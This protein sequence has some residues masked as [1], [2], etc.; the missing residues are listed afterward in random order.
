MMAHNDYRD[1]YVKLRCIFMQHKPETT[2]YYIQELLWK[3][4]ESQ[5]DIYDNDS[6]LDWCR[7]FIKCIM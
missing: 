3:A 1:T 4:R 2:S 7:H 5:S 6:G